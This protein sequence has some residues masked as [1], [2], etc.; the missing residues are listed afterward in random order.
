MKRHQVNANGLALTRQERSREEVGGARQ[1]KNGKGGGKL[2]RVPN[3]FCLLT[4][5]AL[6]AL[7][8]AYVIQPA[9]PAKESESE[10]EYV[11]I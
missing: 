11:K 4:L 6:L 8:I 7:G 3:T 5:T 10:S 2:N 9:W 1:Q